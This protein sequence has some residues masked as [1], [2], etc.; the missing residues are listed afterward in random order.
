M[1]QEKTG[2]GMVGV[3]MGGII[4]GFVIMLVIWLSVLR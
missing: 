3:F 1:A 2:I 4:I